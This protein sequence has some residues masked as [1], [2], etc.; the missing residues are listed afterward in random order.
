MGV[1]HVE[2]GSTR[3]GD[4]VGIFSKQDHQL[5]ENI[6]DVIDDEQRGRFS[7]VEPQS[8]APYVQLGLAP[9]QDTEQNPIKRQKAL[10]ST[11]VRLVCMLVEDGHGVVINTNIRHLGPGSEMFET[12]RPPLG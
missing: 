10:I 3:A 1:Y 2:L 8:G 4:Y 7:L 6:D 5:P 11:A 12:Q 9:V